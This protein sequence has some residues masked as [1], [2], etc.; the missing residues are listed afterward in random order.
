MPQSDGGAVDG[1][2]GYKVYR[3]TSSTGKFKCVKTTTALKFCDTKN[4]KPG[5]YKY[6][7]VR[8]Y[9]KSGKKTYYGPYSEVFK[10]RAEMNAPAS[11]KTTQGSTSI[12]VTW[13]KVTGATGY[14]IY[15]AASQDGEFAKIKTV[16]TTSYTNSVDNFKRYYYK[17]RA[18]RNGGNE[19][20]WNQ[21]E[22]DGQIY[23]INAAEGN[24][25]VAFTP[26]EIN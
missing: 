16:K 21:V 15:R 19:T 13:S 6:Y 11:V 5:T 12:K 23:T 26:E 2:K 17:V 18:T 3:A 7:K 20:S 8:A 14:Q 24:Q 22:L 25:P 9:T 4:N 10:A 1:A